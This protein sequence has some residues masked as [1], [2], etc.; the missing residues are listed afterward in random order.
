MKR[1]T[2]LVLVLLLSIVLCGC[3]LKHEFTAAT[4]VAPATCTKC[5][6]TEGEPLGH[7]WSEATCTE[8]KT[9]RSCGAADG[10]PLGHTEVI[11][12]G[13]EA[14][15]TAEG[16]TEGKHCS[17]CGEVL[18]PQEIIPAFG[19]DEV[20]D[21]AVE[22]TCTE[23]GLTEGKHCSLCG[24]VFV[25]QEII[26]AAGHDWESAT[27]Y[28]PKTCRICGY[29]EGEAL[30]PEYIFQLLTPDT[31]TALT[32][33]Q[34]KTGITE[35]P[36]AGFNSD[37]LISGSVN[38]FYELDEY[39]NNSSVKINI[40][41][42]EKDALLLYTT[43][44]LNG[45]KP[46]DIG[47][48]FDTESVSL[49]LP[50]IDDTVY[51][52]DYTTIQDFI[53][54]YSGDAVAISVRDSQAAAEYQK[55]LES[56]FSGDELKSCLEKYKDIILSIATVHNVTEERRDYYFAGLDET[57][58][59]LIIE[60]QPTRS[61]WRIML[62]K[63]FTTLAEDDELFDFFKKVFALAEEN[64]N[65]FESIGLDFDS[66]FEELK[67]EFRDAMVDALYDVDDIAYELEGLTL[68]IVHNGQRVVSL[69]I[70]SEYSNTFDGIAYESADIS[71]DGRKDAI[72]FY[73]YGVPEIIG[74]NEFKS[75]NGAIKGKLIVNPDAFDSYYDGPLTLGYSFGGKTSPFDIAF[76][77][78][79]FG[80]RGAMTRDEAGAEI[81]ASFDTMY[82]SGEIN[83]DYIREGSGNSFPGSDPKDLK[84]EMDFLVA[85]NSI[86]EKI[87]KADLFGQNG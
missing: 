81:N 11:D 58:N 44:V 70:I 4:C 26:A 68:R 60:F 6:K 49:T 23:S 3:C 2:A 47:I 17:L 10:N 79:E 80:L 16:L 35:K 31:K 18:V 57:Q 43:L 40:N 53:E 87:A 7:D 82:E 77:F 9:C 19:H 28:T 76:S 48:R 65:A 30:G 21:A 20:I 46:V 66:S 54:E 75:E 29:Q 34:K 8:P 50:G 42:K 13:I 51:K 86:A 36:S 55:Q 12:E 22:P 61:D 67:E 56:L 78:D 72:V 24:E 15:C 83:I 14:T 37:I 85:Y 62:R 64:S 74:C 63:L 33:I 52:T 1:I 25:E 41:T 71:S 39:I 32:G 27:F 38:G 45:S 59:C 84:S 69:G 73:N 5:G